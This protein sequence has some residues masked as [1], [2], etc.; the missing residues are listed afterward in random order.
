MRFA[1]L[2]LPKDQGLVVTALAANAPAAQVGIQPNDVLLKVGDVVLGKAEDL[3]DGLKAAG[4]TPVTLTVIR[5]GK[6]IKIQVQPQ[7]H[8]TMGPVRPEPPA[9]WLG[10]SVSPLEP[11][12]RSQLKLPQNEG[13]LVIEIVKDGPAAQA[14][15]K[16]HDILISLNRKILDSQ[17]K[18]IKQVQSIGEK[19]VPLELIR[20]G[21]PQTITVTPRHRKSAQSQ[22]LAGAYQNWVY[23]VVRPGAVLSQ[24][25]RTPEPGDGKAFAGDLVIEQISGPTGAS[26]MS[27]RLDELDTEIKQLHKAIEELNKLLEDKK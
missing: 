12:L 1:H 20:E 16:L 27:K 15:V 23:E 24:L 4:E 2:G 7:V 11:A 18:L 26:A 8:V 3:D 6:P 9:F 13:L 5:G 19:P 22:A 17:E 10:V 21:K 14:D 25:Y